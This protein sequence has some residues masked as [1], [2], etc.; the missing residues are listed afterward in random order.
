M[1]D[2]N[3]RSERPTP[4]TRSDRPGSRERLLDATVELLRLKGPT[5]SGTKE[6][7]ERA[8]APRGSFYFHFP[9][10]KDQLVAEAVTR[11]AAAT[12]TAMTQ[13]LRDRTVGLP[14]RIE[15]LLTAVADDLAGH[16]YGPGC[17]VAATTLDT[18]ATTPALRQVTATAFAS[19]ASLLTQELTTEGIPADHATALADSVIAGLEGATML[20]RARLDTAPLLHVAATLRTAATAALQLDDPPSASSTPRS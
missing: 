7:L 14:E 10:G 20:A 9:N 17:A 3:D 16:D 12:A 4:P 13:A 5:A 8:D 1:P 15:A 2:V 19:W 18:A 6:I 11:A